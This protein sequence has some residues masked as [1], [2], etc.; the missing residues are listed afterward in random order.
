MKIAKKI[1]VSFI[2]ISVIL[3]VLGTIVFYK[4]AKDNLKNSIFAHLKTTAHSRTHHV[5]TFLESRKE[6]AVQLSQSVIVENLLRT[7]NKDPHYIDKFNTVM[8]RLDRTKKVNKNILETFI[9]NADGKI[10]AS[11][12]RNKIGLDR[13][14]DFY[15]SGAQS[16]PYIRDVYSSAPVE[17]SI[18]FSAP[19]IVNEK[20]GPIGVVAARANLNMLNEITM[21]RNGLGETGEVYLVN[22]YGHMLTPSRFIKDTSEQKIDTEVAEHYLHDVGKASERNREPRLY[23]D[24][25]GVRVL[26]TSEY[27]PEMQWFLLV[28]IDK[29]EAFAPLN[30]LKFVFL[31]MI[32]VISIVAWLAGSFIARF[33]SK[34]I[35]KLHE[36]I[37]IIGRGNLDYKVGTDSNDE[38]GQLSKAFDKMTGDLRKTTTSIDELNKEIDERKHAE[39]AL[40]E[41]E[42]RLSQIVRGSLIATFVID[43]NHSLTH[44]NNACENLTG[45]SA[46]EIIGT[47]KQWMAFYSEE[48]PT[49][50]DL[51]VDE[52]A[53]EESIKYYGD[54]HQ[55]SA[56]IKGAYE[57]EVFLPDL[58][59]WVFL[60]AAPLRDAEGK[61][62]GAIETLQDITNQKM[63]EE[64][65][66]ESRQQ[67]ADIINFLPDA[68]FAI[69]LEGKV[70]AWN[71]AIEEMTGVKAEDMLG[72]GDYE[73]ALPFYGVRRPILI[74][75]VFKSDEEVE[76]KYF[77]VRKEGNALISEAEVPHVKGENLFLWGKAGPI[78]D[79]KGNVIGAIESIRNVTERWRA[80]KALHESEEKY[81]T[82]F[83]TS[84]DFVFITTR[85]GRWIDV[86]DAAV[87]LFGHGNRD[88][89]FKCEIIELFENP[90]DV[91]K[92]IRAVEQRG[93]TKD[94]S[95]NFR[96]KNGSIINALV[97]SVVRKDEY[98]NVTGYQGTIKDVTERKRLEAQLLHAQKMEAVG[99]LAGGIAHDFNNI[100]QAVSG[101]CQL[102]LMRKGANEPDRNYLNQINGSIQRATELVHQ[103]LIFSHKVEGKFRP[104]GINRKVVLVHELLKE[105]IPKM[106]DIELHLADDLKTINA[107]PI[108]LEQIIMNLAVNARDAMPDGGKLIIKTENVVLTGK[109]CTVHLGA[110][111]GEHVLLSI[112]DTG[113]GIEKEIQE[114]IFEPFYTTKEAGRGTGLGLA[115]VYGIV[116]NHDGY[117]MCYSEP[118][119]GTIF[120]IYFPALEAGVTEREPEPEEVEELQGGDETILLVDDEDTILDISSNMLGQYGYTAIEARSGEDAI[121]IYKKEKDRIGLVILDVGMPG[122]GGHKCLRKLLKIDPVVRVII[123]SGYLDDGRVRETKEAGA[124]GFIGKP[125]QLVDLLKKVRE[126][127]D[128]GVTTSRS[129]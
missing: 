29:S 116:K 51:I 46:S 66:R 114:H 91:K 30:R 101:Y 43:R 38:I 117:I 64:T 123:S 41:G 71:R 9:L 92:Y 107:D 76:E 112:S 31:T 90:Q 98:G 96:R 37:E 69:D 28:Q 54:K 58:C 50:A 77:F 125:Y 81:R 70:V 75:L 121:K 111:P 78:F 55:I 63:T 108:Q 93:F 115:I 56:L 97:T 79:Y 87:E 84:R 109:Y 67:Y 27:L 82:F 49:M 21:D 25:R 61:I 35:Q 52:V 8:K 106:V 47:K 39:E 12:N 94:F 62:T 72:K 126:V 32:F 83:E 1:S 36:G 10:V 100:L 19:I 86:N 11:S 5:K 110:T 119:Q 85:E 2:I 127:L 88:E 3:M 4:V 103:L 73:Y 18:V 20:E 120:R 7:N 129:P 15:F 124:A 6:R 122:M 40:R 68:T 80:Q 16:G 22:R 89:L 118:G 113:F 13:Y 95:I 33:I 34:P 24:Y 65:L 14:A 102:L 128:G 45:I 74:D 26:G 105:T 17:E 53:E 42:R 99:T 104:V 60:T 57:A 23:K 59:K 48:R 44:W